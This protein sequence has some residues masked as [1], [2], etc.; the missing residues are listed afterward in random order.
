MLNPGMITP[1]RFR[2]VFKDP[3]ALDKEMNAVLNAFVQEG[4]RGYRKEMTVQD[5]VLFDAGVRIPQHESAG[6]LSQL[7][8]VVDQRQLIRLRKCA[9]L[10]D[11]GFSET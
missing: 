11:D 3:K 10:D 8:K 1:P 5:Y 2:S 4:R 7:R 9:G 6:L